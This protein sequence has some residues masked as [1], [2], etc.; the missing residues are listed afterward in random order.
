MNKEN[1]G[2]DSIIGIGLIIIIFIWAMVISPIYLFVLI[3]IAIMIFVI[4]SSSLSQRDEYFKSKNAIMGTTAGIGVL[5]A[6]LYFLNKD[7]FDYFWIYQNNYI[8]ISMIFVMISAFGLIYYKKFIPVSFIKD[9]DRFV[10]QT[11]YRDYDYIDL[12][13]RFAYRGLKF[14]SEDGEKYTPQ[15]LIKAKTPYKS[16]ELSIFDLEVEA[17]N[18]KDELKFYYQ[19]LIYDF[20]NDFMFDKNKNAEKLLCL[21]GYNITVV[22][23]LR[24][25]SAFKKALKKESLLYYKI[26]SFLEL[27]MKKI[28][29]K[30]NFKKIYND[31]YCSLELTLLGIIQYVRLFANF[32]V[33]DF[34]KYVLTTKD[35]NFLSAFGSLPTDYQNISSTT[36]APLGIG[37][38][39]LFYKIHYNWFVSIEAK[40]FE[41]EWGE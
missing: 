9:D 24:S 30:I 2:M 33:G 38:Y 8:L 31:N 5:G 10:Q 41:K 25:I 27:D 37:Y 26:F 17:V 20:Y 22:Y 29:I 35:R 1:S 39:Y 14:R 13:D 12:R 3:P 28:G 15:T 32:P 11:M 36:I 7:D 40:E 19:K 4:F 16:T 21:Y 6:A 34:G 23:N 18:D